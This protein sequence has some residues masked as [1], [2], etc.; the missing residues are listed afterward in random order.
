VS[1]HN[2]GFENRVRAF[3]ARLEERR[4]AV[5]STQNDMA[6]A[7]GI[8][9]KTYVLMESGRWL[10]APRAGHH[11]VHV[12]HGFDPALAAAYAALYDNTVEDF[13]V[14]PPAPA[15]PPKLDP[16]QARHA[17]DAA[18]YAAAEGEDIPAKTLRPVVA[19]VLAALH[20]AGMSLEQ[21]A[22]VAREAA[23][24]SKPARGSRGARDEGPRFRVEASDAAREAEA[25]GA[26]REA[27]RRRRR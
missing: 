16:Q 9:R 19:A 20:E 22:E 10:P 7:L 14:A 26:R 27:E 25:E 12:L 4:K 11:M 6:S 3:A 15:A 5:N 24:K 17:Y 13:G 8:S 23:A 1:R 18:V 21:A 2:P